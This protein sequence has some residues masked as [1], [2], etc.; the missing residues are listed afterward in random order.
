[1]HTISNENNFASAFEAS[2]GKLNSYLEKKNLKK[3]QELETILSEFKA[4]KAMFIAKQTEAVTPEMMFEAIKK[5]DMEALVRYTPAF[6]DIS[7]LRLKGDSLLHFALTY[8]ASIEMLQH[9]IS[10]GPAMVQI[11]DSEGKLPLHIA[12]QYCF[13]SEVALIADAFPGA[14]K[15][16]D[17][18]GFTPLHTAVYSCSSFETIE[19]VS[20]RCPVAAQMRDVVSFFLDFF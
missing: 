11:R 8:N 7:Q 5:N 1:M 13:S 9:L 17:I 16:Q 14:L 2:F 20:Q 6:T 19:L 3:D 10:S 12:C 18:H 15:E 4:I